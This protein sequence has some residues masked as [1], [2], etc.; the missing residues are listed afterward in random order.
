[1]KKTSLTGTISYI[2]ED[3]GF[4]VLQTGFGKYV[5]DLT[6]LRKAR[7]K[8]K[9][10]LPDIRVEFTFVGGLPTSFSFEKTAKPNRK[11]RDAGNVRTK[12]AA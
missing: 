7:I 11:N 12:E 10:C 8:W 2:D 1:M 3:N 5:V 4:A 9:G 6:E